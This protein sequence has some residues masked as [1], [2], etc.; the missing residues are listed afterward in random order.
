MTLGIL[1]LSDNHFVPAL[2]QL[3]GNY[4]RNHGTATDI[5]LFYLTFRVMLGLRLSLLLAKDLWHPVYDSRSS[6]VPQGGVHQIYGH[7]PLMVCFFTRR[8][9]NLA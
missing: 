8:K 6:E 9:T 5:L 7:T 1:A 4:L 3:Y 2:L